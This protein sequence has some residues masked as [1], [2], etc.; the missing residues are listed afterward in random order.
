MLV[1]LAGLHVVMWGRLTNRNLTLQPWFYIL[2]LFFLARATIY[3]L[4]W[5]QRDKKNVGSTD[6]L[7]AVMWGQLTNRYLTPQ[8]WFLILGLFFLGPGQVARSLIPQGTEA[9]EISSSFRNLHFWGPF[10]IQSWV[11]YLQPFEDVDNEVL[12]LEKKT[13]TIEIERKIS[14]L[15]DHHFYLHF[16]QNLKPLISLMQVLSIVLE[17]ICN[18]LKIDSTIDSKKKKGQVSKD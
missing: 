2:G 18:V 14:R 6:G 13:Q 10:K 12:A 17:V 15:L 16:T 4:I 7:H 5:Y 3:N 9:G 8:P 11:I 1:P